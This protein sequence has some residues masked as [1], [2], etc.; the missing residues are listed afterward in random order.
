VLHDGMPRDPIQV[1][2]HAG[3]KVAKMSIFM[4]SSAGN[5]CNQND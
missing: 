1:Q 2:G 3:L 4:I 5:A